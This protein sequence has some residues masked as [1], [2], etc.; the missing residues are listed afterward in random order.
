MTLLTIVALL[1]LYFYSIECD[2]T[3]RQ[4]DSRDIATFN[5]P[6]NL[7]EQRVVPV[8]P[9]ANRRIFA[10]TV[11]GYTDEAL[12]E[13]SGIRILFTERTGGASLP[14]HDSLNL[15]IHVGDEVSS[16]S[17]NRKTLLRALGKTQDPRHLICARQVHGDGA[18]VVD[19][20]YLDQCD[21]AAMGCVYLDNTDALLTSHK[22]LP[23]LMLFADC[24]PVILVAEGPVASVGVVHAGWRGA[25]LGVSGKAARMLAGLA[26][27]APSEIIAYIGPHICG[28]CYEV[29][30]EVADSFVREFGGNAVLGGRNV[31]LSEA[32]TVDLL[33][34][35]L[36]VGA[37]AKVGKCTFEHTD[38]F[39]SF[40]ASGATG[41]HGALAFI[42]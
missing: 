33:R 3:R 1:A 27:C 38:R 25:L 8:I 24:V 42:E 22:D 10:D 40:R 26:G 4:V 17:S 9:K 11:A 14:P 6:Y 37:I 36:T 20:S 39:F 12:F 32:V 35:G 5:H 15:A 19:G 2:F 41:R 13:R 21:S 7:G 23:L 28:R 31:D 29:G 34:A 18:A 30:Q 16:V